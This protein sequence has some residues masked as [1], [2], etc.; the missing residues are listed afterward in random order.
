MLFQTTIS[1]LRD[2]LYST[3]RG[4]E[5]DTLGVLAALGAATHDRRPQLLAAGAQLDRLV[6]QLNAT[7]ATDPASPT[8]L[9][10][11]VDAAEGLQQT[12]PDLVDALHQAVGPMQ[13]LVEQR[14]QLDTMLSA[15]PALSARPRRHWS[16]RSTG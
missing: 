13:V 14:S 11:L 2:I 7:I 5:D 1:K 12:A 8:L 4:R 15:G 6:D 3:G 10:A 9:S 16:T